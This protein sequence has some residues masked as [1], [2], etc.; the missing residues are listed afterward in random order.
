MSKRT[1]I[2]KNEMTDACIVEGWKHDCSSYYTYDHRWHALLNHLCLS[3]SLVVLFLR[4]L[5]PG[6]LPQPPEFEEDAKNAQSAGNL[7]WQSLPDPPVVSDGAAITDFSPRRMPRRER[8]SEVVLPQPLAVTSEELPKERAISVV[9]LRRRSSNASFVS[10]RSGSTRHSLDPVATSSEGGLPPVSFP[11]VK[12]YGFRKSHASHRS[13]SSI[14]SGRPGSIASMS[15]HSQRGLSRGPPRS[16]QLPQ[17][18]SDSS[19]TDGPIP[20]TLPDVNRLSV[21]GDIGGRFAQPREADM[22]DGHVRHRRFAN[23]PAIEPAFDR[24]AP[25]VPGRAP[26]LQVFVPPDGRWPSVEATA[27]CLRE[28]ERCGALQKMMLGDLIASFPL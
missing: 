19:Q 13:F 2:A 11:A 6:S 3:Y 23:L 5:P 14:S 15:V 8:I 24:P 10:A 18:S 21:E 20:P 16:F 25:Y 4:S 27:R 28:L 17:G 9:Q 12:R 22:R 1:L 26:I 7:L